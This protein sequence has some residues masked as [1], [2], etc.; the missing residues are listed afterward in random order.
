MI[1]HSSGR[2]FMLPLLA[3][4]FALLLALPAAAQST[5]MV[6]GKVVDDKNQP[7][8]DAKITIDYLDGVNRKQE[9]KTN[10]KG[11]FIQIGL[12]PGNYRVT[13]EKEKLGS[14]A[15]EV[16]VRIG[17]AADVNFQLVPGATAGMSKEEAT[18]NAELRKAFDE[19]VAASQAG[20]FDEA[21]A[22]F[23]RATDVNPSCADCWF[24]IGYAESQ[25]KDNDKAEAAYKK[26]IELK[27][28]YA[29]AYNAL[30]TL[31]NNQRKFDLAAEMSA[32]AAELTS[33]A[34][35]AGA[36][37][38]NADALYNQGVILW[39][40][41]KVAEAKKQFQSAI[42][43]N[44]NHAESHYQLGM[45]L[46]NEGNLA[47]AANEFDTYLRLAPEGPNAGQ[48]RALVTQLKK[49]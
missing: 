5:G 30:A 8:E 36:P 11:E 13:A 16:R 47:D 12:F 49:Y 40:A 27:A 6:K 37:G 46:V 41:G 14:Q 28:D 44:P 39:N 10:K 34:G 22:A 26:A 32:K 18:K 1:R 35:A 21:I 19:G 2:R 17:T 15:F 9:T 3:A 48:A 4:T 43:A 24:N 42:Q 25:K 31:Y 20:N 33:A 38:G 23:T 29:A 45:A 7:V